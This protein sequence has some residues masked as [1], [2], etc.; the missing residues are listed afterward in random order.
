MT[1]N[2]E[3]LTARQLGAAGERIV[4]ELLSN[5]GWQIV[6]TNVRLGRLEV[7]LIAVDLTDGLHFVEVKTRRSRAYGPGREAI[8]EEKLAHMRQAATLWLSQQNRGWARISF[9]CAEVTVDGATHM[10]V[11]LIDVEEN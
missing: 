11:E 3:M 9:D 7:D 5:Q 10:R 1:L 8:T 6:D 2:L 4:A